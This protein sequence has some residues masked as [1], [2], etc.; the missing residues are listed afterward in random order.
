MGAHYTWSAFIDDASEN[1]NPNALSDVAVPQDSFNRKPERGR[2]TFDRPHRFTVNGVWEVP[3]FREQKGFFGRVF[4]GWQLA[5][6]LTLQ[7]GA[8]FTP[9]NGADPA[10]RLSGI[11]GLV[12][13]AIRPVVNSTLD[14][15]SMTVVELYRRWQGGERFF[16]QVTAAEQ[17]GNAG[18]GILRAKGIANID[19][20]LTKSTQIVEGVKMQLR[21]DMFNATNT[22]NFGIPDGRINSAAFLNQWNTDGGR[23]KIQLGMRLTF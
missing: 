20:G 11:S 1:F 22:R 13:N 15:S 2:S 16:R 19:L 21:M 12:G 23:R 3:V 8:P 10:G 9:L 4:G 18:R 5:P 17:I 6:F 7:S 14:V